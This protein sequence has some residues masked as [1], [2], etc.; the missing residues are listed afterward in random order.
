MSRRGRRRSRGPKYFNFDVPTKPSSG[1]RK[2]LWAPKKATVEQINAVA[3]EVLGGG[4]YHTVE[5][6]RRDLA[7]KDRG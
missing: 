2:G 4:R 5:S 6:L 1:N 3:R 7:D